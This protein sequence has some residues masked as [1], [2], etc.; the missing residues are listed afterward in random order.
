MFHVLINKT[1]KTI[2]VRYSNDKKI[3]LLN[4]VILSPYLLK[5]L[6]ELYLIKSLQVWKTIINFV[7]K[8]IEVSPN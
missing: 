7:R 6:V 3:L 1:L 5:K 4:G 8:L 2:E